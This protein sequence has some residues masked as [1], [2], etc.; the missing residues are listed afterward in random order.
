MT[1]GYTCPIYDQGV[2]SVAKG[3]VIIRFKLPELIKNVSWAGNC[4]PADM[5]R[6]CLGGGSTLLS[7]SHVSSTTGESA[8]PIYYQ[9]LVSVEN[10][11]VIIRSKFAEL[12]KNVSW[13]GNRSSGGHVSSITRG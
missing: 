8:G 9:G 10:G 12:I 1:G 13:V 7:R 11:S 3:S 5:F 4:S 6:A 2:V